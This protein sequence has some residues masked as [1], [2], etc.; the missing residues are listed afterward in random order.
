MSTFV[1]VGSGSRYEFTERDLPTLRKRF[2]EWQGAGRPK[3]ADATPKTAPR[4]TKT[5]KTTD[6]KVWADEETAERIPVLEDIRDPRVRARVQAAARAAEDR[7]NML[8]L[9]HGVHISQG[10]ASTGRK[11]S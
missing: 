10:Y 3:P 9:A 11:A 8:L 5:S 6:A 2:A 4:K 1:A 7:L